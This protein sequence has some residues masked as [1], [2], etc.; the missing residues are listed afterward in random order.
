MNYRSQL[1]DKQRIVI[2]IGT[3]LLTL[4]DARIDLLRMERIA[5]VISGLHEMKKEVVLVSSGAVGA[6]MGKLFLNTKPETVAEKQALAAIGQASL[7]R[8]YETFFDEYNKVIGQVLLTR[9]GIEIAQRRENAIN[10]LEQ[11]LKMKVIPIINENDT[12]ATE[13]LEIGDN[14]MLSCIVATLINADLLII[15]TNTDGV[16]T[17]DPGKDRNARRL[18]LVSGDQEELNGVVTDGKS[19]LGSGGMS[20]KI[21]AAGFC[22]KNNIDAIIAEGSDP[23]VLYRI[24]E[25][26]DIGTLFLSNRTQVQTS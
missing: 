10:T 1:R 16:F 4:E 26:E 9:D 25:G 18:S 23:S 2:K 5:R 20:S 19:Q 17:A 22:Q 3:A 21:Q 24:L 11:L 6:G 8:M 7:L 15:L 14:D 12:V 13:E